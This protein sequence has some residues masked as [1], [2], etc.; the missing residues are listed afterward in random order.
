MLGRMFSLYGVPNISFTAIS[1]C[2]TTL[3]VMH[4]LLLAVIRHLNVPES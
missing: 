3:L 4:L 1:A 2:E